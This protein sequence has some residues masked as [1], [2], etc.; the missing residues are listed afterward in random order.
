MADFKSM[1]KDSYFHVLDRIFAVPLTFMEL[2]K[3][4]IMFKHTRFSFFIIYASAFAFAIFSFVTS[5]SNQSAKNM[6]GFIFW[7]NMWHMFPIFQSIISVFD[8]VIFPDQMIFMETKREH[9]SPPTLSTL[10]L[11]KV[12]DSTK[13]E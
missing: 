5:C 6:S 4:C 13:I 8:I 2:C 11:K 10:I 3:I 1:G 12:S 9:T 7:H